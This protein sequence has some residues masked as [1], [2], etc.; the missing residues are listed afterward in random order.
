M[1]GCSCKDTN[2]SLLAATSVATSARAV[3]ERQRMARRALQYLTGGAVEHCAKAPGT[4]LPNAAIFVAEENAKC[5][6]LL[7][8]TTSDPDRSVRFKLLHADPNRTKRVARDNM[9]TFP[10]ELVTVCRQMQ[11]L[12]ALATTHRAKSEH[13]KLL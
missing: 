6:L 1:R 2:S 10:N 11:H 12:A 7:W 8:A 13:D 3:E 9:A 4:A 5:E